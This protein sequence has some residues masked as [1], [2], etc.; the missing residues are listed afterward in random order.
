MKKPIPT[1][2]RNFLKLAGAA[3]MT[4]TFPRLGK[5]RGVRRTPRRAGSEVVTQAE[6]DVRIGID[7][8][9]ALVRINIRGCQAEH[10]I[11]A[12]GKVVAQ[13]EF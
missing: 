11:G 2:R 13:K 7:A 6:F 5:A 12:D 8:A 9:A 4:L 1:N 3:G 10:K